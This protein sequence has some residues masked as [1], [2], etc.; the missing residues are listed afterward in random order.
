MLKKATKVKGESHQV[1]EGIWPCHGSLLLLRNAE[2]NGSQP[3][4]HRD[5]SGTGGV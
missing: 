2:S 1:I 5:D 3:T 4:A